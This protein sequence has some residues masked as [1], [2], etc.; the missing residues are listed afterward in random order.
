MCIDTQ[1]DFEPG[2]TCGVLAVEDVSVGQFLGYIGPGDVH[3]ATIRR[4]ECS[5][6]MVTVLLR[7]YD[8]REFGIRFWGV[9]A[10]EAHQAEGMMLY[11]LCELNEA[12]PIRRFRFVNWEDDSPDDLQIVATDFEVL[13][14]LSE[15][16]E[17]K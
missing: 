10:V 7:S 12:A 14:T 1:R 13:E 2:R 15:R 4:I 11:T 5:T 3:D 8:G 17:E 9:V 6:G 16:S